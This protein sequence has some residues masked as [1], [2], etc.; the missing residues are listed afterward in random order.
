MLILKQEPPGAA[1][2]PVGCSS[3]CSGI[4]VPTRARQF[5]TGLPD[6]NPGC[7]YLRVSSIECKETNSECNE[8][9]WKL[10]EPPT[11]LPCK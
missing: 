10:E 9:L 11:G 1:A 2:A 3:S 6:C 5:R 8:T 7:S 4:P